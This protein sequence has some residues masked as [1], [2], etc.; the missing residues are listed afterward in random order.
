M[1]SSSIGLP[2]RGRRLAGLEL[3]LEAG[4]LVGQ[5]PD[6]REPP[7]RHLDRSTSSALERLDEVRQ[8]AGVSGL[9]DEVVG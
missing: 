7:E 8:G 5:R 9:L 4:G 2:W 3:F 6:P 1:P